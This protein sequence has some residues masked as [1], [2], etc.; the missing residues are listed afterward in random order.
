[1]AEVTETNT[2]TK[3]YKRVPTR[4]H[5]RELDR[6]IARERMRKAKLNRVGKGSF[7]AENWR[8][9]SEK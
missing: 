3:N 1:M 6:E 5:T 8:N 7:F 9:F 4:I 2:A